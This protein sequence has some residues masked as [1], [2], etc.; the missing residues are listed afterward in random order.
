[1]SCNALLTIN[2][3]MLIRSLLKFEYSREVEWFGACGL[4]EMKRFQKIRPILTI[5]YD[6]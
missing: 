5:N 3:F 4:K 6:T 2:F 1:M